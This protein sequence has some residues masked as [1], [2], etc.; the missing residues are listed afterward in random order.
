MSVI[1]NA[2]QPIGG[3]QEPVGVCRYD[4]LILSCLLTTR[5]DWGQKN[6]ALR[7]CPRPGANIC[8]Y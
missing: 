7:R 5:Q 4:S 8:A 1:E 3:T 6:E 2:K